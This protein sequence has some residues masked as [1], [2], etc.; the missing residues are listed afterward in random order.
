MWADIFKKKNWVKILKRF[1]II[2][3]NFFP[4][5]SP[6]IF[7]S[8]NLLKMNLLAIEFKIYWYVVIEFLIADLKQRWMEMIIKNE[9]KFKEFSK[10]ILNLRCN[11]V[12]SVERKGRAEIK[13]HDPAMRKTLIMFIFLTIFHFFLFLNGLFQLPSLYFLSPSLDF[14]FTPPNIPISLLKL[15]FFLFWFW[16]SLKYRPLLLRTKRIE[17]F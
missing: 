15:L 13:E 6:I 1:E 16:P 14:L 9:T 5:K 10:L 12:K 2:K 17:F 7:L 11:K 4:R 3:N 8:Q